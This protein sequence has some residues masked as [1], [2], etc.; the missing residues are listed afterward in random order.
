MH[1]IKRKENQRAK[2]DMSR[3]CKIDEA[4]RSSFTLLIT[5]S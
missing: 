3:L 1:N 5:F 2:L 4:A